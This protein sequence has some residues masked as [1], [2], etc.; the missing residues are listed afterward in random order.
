MSL[1]LSSTASLITSLTILTIYN[2]YIKFTY[3]FL[4]DADLQ[5]P[6]HLQKLEHENLQ[7]IPK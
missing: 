3:V 5:N 2:I 6:L 4:P 1:I 7:L